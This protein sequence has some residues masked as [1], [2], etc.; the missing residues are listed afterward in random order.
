MS[1]M[2]LRLASENSSVVAVVGK[3]HL[4][5]IRNHWKQPVVVGELFILH[6]SHQLSLPC[7]TNMLIPRQQCLE[8]T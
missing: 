2:L 8:L 6:D 4:Q 3:G 7:Y 1:S 5:G